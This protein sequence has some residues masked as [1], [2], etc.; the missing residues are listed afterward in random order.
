MIMNM[1]V[2]LIWMILGRMISLVI[3]KTYLMLV[4]MLI[5]LDPLM[6]NMIILGR[7]VQRFG[8]RLIGQVSSV[9]RPSRLSRLITRHLTD[10]KKF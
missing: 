1:E 10:K 9:N 7:A 6:Y 8:S 4:L 2:G 3:L 5:V